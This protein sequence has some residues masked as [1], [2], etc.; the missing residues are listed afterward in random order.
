[1]ENIRFDNFLILTLFI[2]VI[3]HICDGTFGRVMQ[4][5]D[6]TNKMNYAL[7]I[8]RPVERY[9]EAAKD[10][11]NILG[12]LPKNDNLLSLIDCFYY[13]EYYC[14]LTPLYGPSI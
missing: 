7:K 1:M 8:I 14:I 11:S 12:N 5:E 13:K 6:I 10:E 4:V 9:I 3:K 2:K